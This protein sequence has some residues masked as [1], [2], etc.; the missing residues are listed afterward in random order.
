MLKHTYTHTQTHRT[1]VLVFWG[2]FPVFIFD[3]TV[4]SVALT[5]TCITTYYNIHHQKSSSFLMSSHLNSFCTFIC[6]DPSLILS[7]N[8]KLNLFWFWSHSS[9]TWSE[10]EVS[11]D[12]L[13]NNQVCIFSQDPLFLPT[14]ESILQHLLYPKYMEQI[15]IHSSWVN[16]YPRSASC[17]ALELFLTP[18]V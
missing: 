17:S 10:S 11:E 13:P 14:S 4:S 6:E 12:F 5:T 16:T 3:G 1:L 18:F 9:H 15:R 2:F 7:L 8:E